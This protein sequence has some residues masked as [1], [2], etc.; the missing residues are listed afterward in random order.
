MTQETLNAAKKISTDHSEQIIFRMNQKEHQ[1]FTEFC[2]ENRLKK[3][4]LL[5]EMVREV[6]HT[7]EPFPR[8][9]R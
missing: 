7:F 3:S 2:K 1:R 8:E 9:S 4:T 5:R 6:I